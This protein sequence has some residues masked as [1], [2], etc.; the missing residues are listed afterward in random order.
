[1]KPGAVVVVVSHENC[2]PGQ[3][4]V[5]QES[6]NLTQWT[7]VATNTLTVTTFDF[8]AEAGGGLAGRYYRAVLG[9]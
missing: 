7:S 5:V 3:V 8:A 6:T 1:M 4:V 2:M 9:P